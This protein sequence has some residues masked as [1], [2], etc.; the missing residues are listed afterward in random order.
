[1]KNCTLQWFHANINISIK[2]S[3][4]K[5]ISL[6]YRLLERQFCHT[7]G[8]SNAVRMSLK[9][10]NPCSDIIHTLEG[11]IASLQHSRIDKRTAPLTSNDSVTNQSRRSIE[12]SYLPGPIG[13]RQK[14]FLTVLGGL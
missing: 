7:S 6:I 9:K 8:N 2:L 14:M 4:L 13:A 11:N 12:Y 1:M 5:K 10:K 3:S